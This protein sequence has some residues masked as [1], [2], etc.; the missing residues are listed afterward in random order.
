MVPKNL[1][2]LI[3]FLCSG[4]GKDGAGTSNGGESPEETAVVVA[5]QDDGVSRRMKTSTDG[6]HYVTHSISDHGGTTTYTTQG[7]NNKTT[8]SLEVIGGESFFLS[9]YIFQVVNKASI[10]FV[11]QFLVNLTICFVVGDDFAGHR[12]VEGKTGQRVVV[13][14]TEDPL[15]RP[16][17]VVKKVTSQSRVIM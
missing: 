13:E 10:I 3:M 7:V 2:L 17:T 15:G 16:S 8:T 5:S 14:R 12:A 4:G 11:Y 9:H 1:K 6:E